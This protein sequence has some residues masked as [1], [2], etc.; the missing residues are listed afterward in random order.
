MYKY[1]SFLSLF[2]AE[3]YKANR[4]TGVWILLIFPII[5][6][7]G[8]V[9]YIFFKVDETDPS[10]GY[11]PWIYLLGRYVFG[12]YNYLYPLIVAVFCFSYYDEEYKNGSFKDLLTLPVSKTGIFSIKALYIVQTLLIS[13]LIAY[14]LF[15]IS[16]FVMSYA[17]PHSGFQ[18]YDVRLITLVYFIKLFFGLIAVSFIQFFLSLLFKNFVMPVCFACIAMIFPLIAGQ[19]WKYIDLIPYNEGSVALTDYLDETVHLFDKPDCINLVYA[20]LFLLLSYW[21]FCKTKV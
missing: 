5:I 11:N 18:D 2:Q 12:F 15:L 16:G 20:L 4:N 6:T 8:V 9:F 14:S 3:H 13:L 21:A 17:L 10:F 19:K 1:C 7:L